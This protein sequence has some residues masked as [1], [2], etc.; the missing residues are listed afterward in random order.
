MKSH[1]TPRQITI[2]VVTGV[3]AVA[4]MPGAAVAAASLVT[5]KD[6]VTS[7]KARVVS[8]ALQTVGTATTSDQLESRPWASFDR[9]TN[10]AS[11]EVVLVGPTTRTIALSSLTASATGGDVGVRLRVVEPTGSD[12]HGTVTVKLEAMSFKVANNTTQT[13]SFPSPII[14]RPAAGKS[15]CLVAHPDTTYVPASSA[16]ITVSGNGFLR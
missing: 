9:V 1:F 5:I 8:G 15:V 7:Q 14:G 11:D 6:P 10:N 3:V 2:M 16:T 13:M 12:C 4:L